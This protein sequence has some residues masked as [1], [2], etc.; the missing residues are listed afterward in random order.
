MKEDKGK[1]E[2]VLRLLET[3]IHVSG[4]SRRQLEN[5][6]QMSRGYLTQ[7]FNGR[8]E[9][10]LRHIEVILGEI[11]LSPVAFF[12]MAYGE[13]SGAPTG[14]STPQVEH[15][16]SAFRTMGFGNAAPA[17]PAAAAAPN[18]DIL[19]GLVRDAVA[20][21]LGQRPPSAESGAGRSAAKGGRKPA[22][23]R[24]AKTPRG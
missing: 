17:T 5:R 14:S 7:V 11:G 1:V 24:A 4:I 21:A 15:L 16:L 20:E 9:L 3:A 22:T 8:I 10:K 2:E 23:K 6:L 13:P 18:Q 19:R 12:Q